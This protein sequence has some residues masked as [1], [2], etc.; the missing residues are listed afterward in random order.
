MIT[1]G[2]RSLPW[3]EGLSLADIA[4][5]LDLPADYAYA[6]ID[7]KLIWKKDWTTTVVPDGA[8]IRFR[9]IIAGG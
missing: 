5:E 1:V 4:R 2:D 3:R 8:K 9:G 6:S 7:G